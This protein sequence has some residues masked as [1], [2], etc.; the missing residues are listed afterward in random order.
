MRGK[1]A[2]GEYFGKYSVFHIVGPSRDFQG[3]V[4][5]EAAMCAEGW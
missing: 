2:S 4:L 3:T 1:S 5:E